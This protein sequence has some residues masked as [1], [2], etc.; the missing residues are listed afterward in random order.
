MHVAIIM[1]G[2]RRYAK[3]NLI[4]TITGHQSGM[5]TLQRILG[6]CPK[7]N[8]ETLTVYALSTENFVKRDETEIN[9]IFRVMLEG[10]RKYK[11]QLIGENVRVRIL[12]KIQRLPQDLQET[13]ENL[14]DSTK[15]CSRTLLQVC[16]NY[17]GRNEIVEAVNTAMK[18]GETEITEEV[19]SKYL[20][21]SLEPDL[22]I[23]PG[24]EF[25]L[26]NFLTW[27]S[28]YSELYFTDK[29]WPEF[30]EEEL[31]KAVDYYQSRNRRFG[32]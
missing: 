3:K 22:I 29:L 32:K 1:D 25:R 20:Y 31:K 15:E 6:Y 16:L 10:A 13:C 5:E 17:G 9:N 30:D 14:V 23:R 26:S 18:N 19:I 8:I 11:R 12:G 21:T 24:G 4:Q 27:Q 28:A 2:N 7:Y